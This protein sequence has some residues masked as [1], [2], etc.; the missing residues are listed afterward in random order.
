MEQQRTKE[1]FEKRKGRVTGSAVG[2]ILGLNPWQTDD[3]VL[4]RMVRD[5]HGADSEFK[6]NAATAHGTFYESNA[7]FDYEVSMGKTVVETG[8]HTVSHWLGAS[9]DGLIDDDGIIEVKCPYGLRSHPEPLPLMKRIDEQPHYFA[10]VQIELYCTNRKWCDFFQ[11]TPN[12]SMIE[13]VYRDDQWIKENLPKLRRFHNRYLSELDN[14]AHLEAKEVV[15]DTS[16]DQFLAERYR[17][18]KEQVELANNELELAKQEL[19]ER[20][21][22]NK[23][24]CFGLSIFPVTRSGSVSYAKVVKDHCPDVDLAPYTGKPSTSW[25]IR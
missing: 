22:G 18:A 15:L 13:R 25:T 11:W 9:P 10:Q 8:F 23:A 19:I 1:W 2:A 3:D 7:I 6:G 14:P 21:N 12:G 5:Y 17:A 4:R 24:K 16:E 20:A